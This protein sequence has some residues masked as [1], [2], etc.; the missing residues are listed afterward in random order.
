MYTIT[1]MTSRKKILKESCYLKIEVKHLI[2]DPKKKS[3]EIGNFL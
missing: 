2:I 3:K 1:H